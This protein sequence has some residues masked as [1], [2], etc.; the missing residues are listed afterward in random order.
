MLYS[1]Y[2]NLE[3]LL[4][5]QKTITKTPDEMLFIIT[6]QVH[7]LWFKQIIFELQSILKQSFKGDNDSVDKLNCISRIMD[8]CVAQ[9]NI[10]DTMTPINFLRFRDKLGKASGIQSDQFKTI[11]ILLKQVLNLLN[12]QLSEIDLSHSTF[13][14]S[15]EQYY[16]GTLDPNT[17]RNIIYLFT[18]ETN[19]YFY[20]VIQL[21]L[22]IDQKINLWRFKHIQLVRRII[23]D[24]T[25]T[26]GTN[27]KYLIKGVENPTVFDE[28]IE[29][30]ST[31]RVDEHH[32]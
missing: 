22:D 30:I 1:E 16:G 11:E 24:K 2:L 4:N 3:L 6:H 32:F 21:L 28:I 15:D 29:L 7:E 12:H 10:L 19:N 20:R 9:V 8:L 25:G 31:I 23:G 13:E 26:G 27:K 5:C 17:R 14:V 18:R